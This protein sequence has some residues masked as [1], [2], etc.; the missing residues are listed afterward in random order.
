[1]MGMGRMTVGNQGSKRRRRVNSHLGGEVFS[2]CELLLIP[3]RPQFQNSIRH[4]VSHIRANKL[5]NDGFQD[6]RPNYLHHSVLIIESGS[7]QFVMSCKRKNAKQRASQ[8]L[9][10]RA[11][12]SLSA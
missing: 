9:P 5:P 7:Q 4:C 3:R 1:M 10:Q 12:Y 6:F 11:D 2:K 8:V